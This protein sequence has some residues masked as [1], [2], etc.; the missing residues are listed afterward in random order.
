VREADS[1][2]HIPINA[3]GTILLGASNYMIQCSSSPTRSEVDVANSKGRYLDIGLPSLKNLNGRRK[4]V[5]FAFL[6]VSTMPSCFLWNSAVF[7]TTQ[8][9]DYNLFVVTPGFLNEITV[10][11]SQNVSTRAAAFYAAP[12][13]QKLAYQASNAKASVY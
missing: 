2:L 1:W 9:L 8:N 11:C 10:D 13:V 6:I 7:I 5:L 12:A 4:K 3:I